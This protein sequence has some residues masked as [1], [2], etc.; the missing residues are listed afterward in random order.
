M[1][2][3]RHDLA[4]RD[5]DSDY[6]LLK[7]FSE[8]YTR[9]DLAVGHNAIRFDKGVIR[10]R[11]IKHKLP[12]IYPVVVDDTYISALPIAFT[13]HRLDYISQYL[14]LGQKTNHP[15]KLWVDVM[16]GSKKALE[17]TI[18]YCKQDVILLE[19]VY[20]ALLPYIK[21][22]LN[23]AVF[24]ENNQLC[25]GCGQA[26]LVK[27]SIRMTANLGKRRRWRCKNCGRSVTTGINLLQNVKE[28]PR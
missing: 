22:N 17:D 2:L 1:D 16:R 12:D 23:R 11:L 13:S 20:N 9:A 6:G 25:P 14:N 24:A 10:S 15:Y 27:D 28:Y 19:R 5:D 4:S 7:Q 8:V 3:S 21:T 18:A 26:T